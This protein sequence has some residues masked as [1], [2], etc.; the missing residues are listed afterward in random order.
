LVEAGEHDLA[1]GRLLE[2]L[3]GIAGFGDR[4]QRPTAEC[5]GELAAERENFSYALVVTKPD[6]PYRPALLLQAV[7][8]AA[9]LGTPDEAAKPGRGDNRQAP[10][11]PALTR[12]QRAVGRMLM[13]GL[14]N[15]EIAGQLG[16]ALRTVEAEVTSLRR[17]SGAQ[18]R[19]ELAVWLSDHR[20]QLPAGA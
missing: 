12:R 14:K 13:Q 9:E 3:S 10:N 17:R 4:L 2:W 19:A 18:T 8:C 6:S 15:R 16:L 1:L 7:R 5:T 20:G 11:P